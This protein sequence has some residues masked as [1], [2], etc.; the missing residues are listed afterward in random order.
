MTNNRW[1]RLIEINAFNLR[2]PFCNQ[3]SFIA[4][5]LAIRTQFRLEYPFT[6]DHFAAFRLGNHVKN[7]LT[8]KMFYF[9]STSCF[10]LSSIRI[11]H[12][13]CICEWVW[14]NVCNL[15]WLIA[16]C[17]GDFN[18]SLC[19]PFNSTRCSGLWLSRKLPM[20]VER[21]LITAIIVTYRL[22]FEPG[23]PTDLRQQ[24]QDSYR[25]RSVESKGSRY[26]DR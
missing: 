8:D 10:L 21:L 7:I 17:S 5:D 2:E 16:H 11:R 6:V 23:R 20:F 14:I 22:A 1:V 25:D 3:T 26:Q 15:C 18:N 24:I 9:F 4:F 13:F 19:P 12:G